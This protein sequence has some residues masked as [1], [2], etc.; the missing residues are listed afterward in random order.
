MER[1]CISISFVGVYTQP[2]NIPT[3]DNDFCKNLFNVPS[4]TFYGVSPEGF[5]I[6]VNNKPFPLIIIGPQRILF[7][8]ASR[9]ML[10][11][12]IYAIKRKLSE[13]GVN[14]SFN[15]YGVNY[16]YEWTELEDNSDIWLWNH[17]V[18][19]NLSID[20]GY[21]VCNGISLRLSTNE[22]KVMNVQV[23]QR[24]G[25]R[26]GIFASFNHH[27]N[28]LLQEFPNEDELTEIYNTSQVYLEDEVILKIIENN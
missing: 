17:F 8:A 6:T 2:T 27:H 19:P 16:E 13:L 4:D 1:K 3:L 22:N 24:A 25:I 15:A 5:V 11:Q 7:K 12:Y 28:L 10:F 18:N 20:N 26:N 9:E 23:E 14:L 21:R